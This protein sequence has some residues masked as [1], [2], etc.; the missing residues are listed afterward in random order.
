MKKIMEVTPG[1]Y[2]HRYGGEFQVIAIGRNSNDCNQKMVIYKSL[3]D[4]DFPSGTIWI[5]TMTEFTTPGR[6]IKIDD[7]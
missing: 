1:I 4:T 6:F 2:R 7:V 3:H 5:R